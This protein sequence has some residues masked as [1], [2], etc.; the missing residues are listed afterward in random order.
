MCINP[1]INHPTAATPVAPSN[2]P[3]PAA[4]NLISK[5]WSAV[6]DVFVAI[7]DFFV[8]IANY[9]SKTLS[10]MFTRTAATPTPTVDRNKYPERFAVPEEFRS[11]D[12][13]YPEYKP[14]E[15][16]AG[17]VLDNFNRVDGQKLVWAQNPD[18]SQVAPQEFK[19]L[20]VATV[21]LDPRTGRPLNPEGR[22]GLAGQGLLGKWGANQAGDPIVTTVNAQTGNLE[23][24]VIQRKDTGAWALPG[25]MMDPGENIKKTCERELKEESGAT[26][27]FDADPV[28]QGIVKD[29]RNTDNAWMETKAIHAHISQRQPLEAGD[30]ARAAKWQAVTPEFVQSMYAS[31]CDLVKAALQRIDI[32]II[33]GCANKD[34]ILAILNA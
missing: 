2:T 26:V 27:A 32:N 8:N 4:Q 17:A 3:T 33:N 7:K 20:Q 19:S 5:V 34:A 24:L 16:T 6:K 10:A 15:F 22:T 31:H 28:Y 13:A 11:W 30:D 25:G 1:V 18:F 9:V 21:Q 14:A 12:V 29:P 23:L